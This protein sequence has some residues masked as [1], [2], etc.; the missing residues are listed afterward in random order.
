M[1]VELL[2]HTPNPEKLVASA[3]KLCYSKKADI[4]SLMDD[5]TPM[6]I[7]SF[8]ARLESMHH[9]SPMEHISFTFGI[10]GVSRA[11]L[12]QITR[13]RIGASFSVRS[14][15]YCSENDFDYII[16]E[17]IKKHEKHCVR[18]KA[19]MAEI[20][21]F[22]DKLVELG[23]PKEDARMVLPNACAT[24]MI[25]TMN[26]RE[27]FHFAALR[28]CCYDDKTEVLTDKGWKY[29]RDLDKTEKFYSMNPDTFKTEL[30][31]AQDYIDELYSGRMISVKSQSIDL[32]TTPNHKMFV[33]YS[34]DNKKFKFD[35][36]DKC[37][38]HKRVLMKKN[39]NRISGKMAD[40]FTIP[41]PN[42]SG[43]NSKKGKKQNF[44][45][46]TVSIKDFMTFLGMYISDGYA[47]KVGYHYNVGISKGNK[48]KIDKY[49]DILSRLTDNSIA[50]FQEKS[51]AWK[52]QVHDRRLYDY[53]SKLGKVKDKHIPNELFEYDSSILEYLFEGLA[54]GDMNNT[55]TIYSTISPQLANDFS[56]LCLHLG[57]STTTCVIDRVGDQRPIKASNGACEHLITT[58]NVE[59]SISI[60]R[61]KNEPIIKSNTNNAFSEAQYSG[62]VYCVNLKKNHLLYVRRNGKAVWCGNCRAQW[63]IR[64]L[65]NEMVRQVKEIAPTLFKHLGAACVQNGFCPEGAKSCGKAPTLERLL[66]DHQAVLTAHCH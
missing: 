23:V 51:G 60:N 26:A 5:L 61:H 31:E 66:D 40:T 34:Y 7:N 29:F 16:P 2:E 24:R 13:H 65:A 32:L 59:Y 27:L 25:V 17:S 18:Y 58:R 21:N 33:S 38:N 6:N 57:I 28:C 45:K 36:A 9:E 35:D 63:E 56:R 4:Q 50:V 20:G 64:A 3:A 39:C 37:N 48:E 8:V 12:A 19:L 47:C 53:F 41:A 22:Y 46:K 44:S 54:D 42:I 49:A 11:L 52:I 43:A 14:Q 10:E 55:H 62:H 15:R 30:V 1:K